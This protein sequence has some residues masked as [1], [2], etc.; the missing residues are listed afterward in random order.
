M[1]IRTIET[2]P[3]TGCLYCDGVSR[4]V[5]STTIRVQIQV[6]KWWITILKYDRVC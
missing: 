1:K 5:M 6:W 3:V 2:D 4:L